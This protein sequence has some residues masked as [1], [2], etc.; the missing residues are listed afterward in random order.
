VVTFGSMG[1]AGG[2]DQTNQVLSEAFARVQRPVIVQAGWQNIGGNSTARVLSIGYAPHD[3]LF[4]QA[5]LVIHHAGSGTAHAT[6]LAGV[7]S[8]PIPHMFDQYY[9][10][11][12]LHRRGVAPRPLFRHELE[13]RALAGRVEQACNPKL[14]AR[15]RDLATRMCAERGVDTAAD[16]IER[17]AR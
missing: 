10:A 16:A 17:L 4:A 1:G 12:M 14:A 13:P 8:V 5:G 11:H 6:C 3:W 9:W 7:P 15:A 2:A